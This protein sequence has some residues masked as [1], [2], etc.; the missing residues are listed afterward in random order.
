MEYVH[1]RANKAR[2]L[3]KAKHA[4]LSKALGRPAKIAVITHKI[5]SVCLLSKT[6]KDLKPDEHIYSVPI[7]PDRHY[8]LDGVWLN[9]CE[10]VNADQYIF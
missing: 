3:I 9:N 7:D 5:F 10:A 8:P 1:I 2:A 4:E 6:F